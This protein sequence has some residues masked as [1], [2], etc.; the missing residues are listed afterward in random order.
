[1]YQKLIRGDE[2]EEQELYGMIWKEEREERKKG[3]SKYINLKDKILNLNKGRGLAGEAA[4]T[5]PS[6]LLL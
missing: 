4:L 6:R 3:K 2:C 5:A 1:M